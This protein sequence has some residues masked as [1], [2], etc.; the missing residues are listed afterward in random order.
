MS[1]SKYEWMDAAVRE[2]PAAAKKSEYEA[3]RDLFQVAL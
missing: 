1:A 2:N 3:A